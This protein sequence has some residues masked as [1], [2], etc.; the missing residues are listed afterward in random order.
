MGCSKLLELTPE[1]HFFR[2][3][4][5]IEQFDPERTLL[6]HGVPDHAHERSDATPSCKKDQIFPSM[7][8]HGKSGRQGGGFQNVS[9]LESVEK[10]WGARTAGLSRT[11]SSI[12]PP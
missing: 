8:A 11:V 12:A 5:S 4:A 10:W 2:R 1:N 3:A 7:R 6:L 9:D